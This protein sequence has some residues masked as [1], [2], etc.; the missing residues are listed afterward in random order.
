MSYDDP[1][2]LRSLR[3]M[4]RELAVKFAEAERE[5]RHQRWRVALAF[6]EWTIVA[7]L[8][9]FVAWMILR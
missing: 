2:G 3:Q 5:R 8:A 4:P 1:H 7:I 6:A 9:M